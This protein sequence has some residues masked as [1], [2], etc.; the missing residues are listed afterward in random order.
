MKNEFN[1]P[2]IQ[3]IGSWRSFGWLEKSKSPD[4]RTQ[5]MQKVMQNLREL[6]FL[7]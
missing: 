4:S 5:I 1:Q 3:F 7:A 6:K 2:Q